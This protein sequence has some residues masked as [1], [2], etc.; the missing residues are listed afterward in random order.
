MYLYRRVVLNEG[1]ARWVVVEIERLKQ[2][3]QLR[4]ENFEKTAGEQLDNIN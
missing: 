1:E 3:Q 2:E 4:M